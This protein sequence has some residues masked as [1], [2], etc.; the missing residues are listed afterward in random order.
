MVCLPRCMGVFGLFDGASS[1]AGH[2][3]TT[4][5]LCR[6]KIAA[7]KGKAWPPPSQPMGNQSNT[8]TKKKK[9]KFAKVT[10]CSSYAV[11]KRERKPIY[12]PDKS[13]RGPRGPG[14][15]KKTPCQCH[16][17]LQGVNSPMAIHRPFSTSRLAKQAPHPSRRLGK[18]Q[19]HAHNP[20]EPTNHPQRRRQP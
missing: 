1:L 20:P 15:P 10:V 2:T 6:A 7:A 11:Y 14:Y 12:V 18:D 13:A 17:T 4:G 9:K 8:D 3:Q 16:A 5:G 19:V